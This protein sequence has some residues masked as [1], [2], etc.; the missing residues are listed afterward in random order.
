MM[1]AANIHY[2]LAD[3]VSGLAPGGIGAFHLLARRTG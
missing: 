1:M 3:R 2:E